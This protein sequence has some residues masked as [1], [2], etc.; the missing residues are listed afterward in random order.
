[1]EHD[2]LWHKDAHFLGNNVEMH[3]YL[4]VKCKPSQYEL[5]EY[6]QGYLSTLLRLSIE[7]SPERLRQLNEND[8][9]LGIIYQHCSDC[10]WKDLLRIS[11]S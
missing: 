4:E 2:S 8:P 9:E 3:E 6:L 11:N 1:M 7:R 10:R 5:I